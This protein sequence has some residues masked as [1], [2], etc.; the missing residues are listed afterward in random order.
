MTLVEAIVVIFI[1][2][3]VLL[4][5]MEI[6]LGGFR[7]YRHGIS[8]E[9]IIQNARNVLDR[10][11]LEVIGGGVDFELL[12]NK[13]PFYV[14]EEHSLLKV[15]FED[16]DP[17]FVGCYKGAKLPDGEDVYILGML[18]GDGT[19]QPL[20]DGYDGGKDSFWV[21]VEEFKVELVPGGNSLI[22]GDGSSDGKG[23]FVYL[24]LA[25]PGG[26]ETRRFK[27]SKYLEVSTLVYL[28]K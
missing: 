7:S 23:V 21:S 19:V 9:D 11:R 12:D 8:R 2:A 18:R 17:L 24:K 13:P 5:L 15:D 28:R 20:T 10:I 16:K 1:L 6:L 14:D 22:Y 27:K 25:G 4:I 3:I 26:L